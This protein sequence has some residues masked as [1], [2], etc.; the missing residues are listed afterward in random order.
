MCGLAW[1]KILDRSSQRAGSKL[2]LLV[3]W[4]QKVQICREVELQKCKRT[5]L[6][7]LPRERMTAGSTHVYRHTILIRRL[8]DSASARAMADIANIVRSRQT[9]SGVS[10]RAFVVQEAGRGDW[11]REGGGGAQSARYCFD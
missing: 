7:G 5:E 10:S 1:A 9:A 4:L 3:C 2:L 8:P 6:R 11:G